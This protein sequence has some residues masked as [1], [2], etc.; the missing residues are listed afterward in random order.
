MIKA[1]LLNILDGILRPRASVRRLLDAGHGYEVALQLVLL[2]YLVLAIFTLA[3]PGARSETDT[4]PLGWYLTGL[5]L[6][7]VVYLGIVAM[8][9][10][11]GRFF[12]GKGRWIDAHLGVAW[13]VLLSAFIEPMTM[14][15][16]IQLSRI[17]EALGRGEEVAAGISGGA[18]ILFVLAGGL[19][20]WLLA[21]CVA[22]LHR[23]ASTW[24][25]LGV[26]FGLSI[27]VSM[28][29]MAL[30]PAA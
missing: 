5:L 1:A 30:M 7:F 8:V 17:G 24:G 4:L 20:L 11:V 28:L 16:Q 9:Y 23:F 3:I 18:L 27:G 2:G 15:A 13:Y 21:S 12:G 29:W 14:P 10:G 22:E 19:M 25:V 26:I 6:Q